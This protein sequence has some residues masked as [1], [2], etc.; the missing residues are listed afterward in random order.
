[1]VEFSNYAA[2]VTKSADVKAVLF[3]GKRVTTAWTAVPNWGYSYVAF[4][5][6]HGAHTFTVADGSSARLAAFAYGHSPLA[7]S[8]SGY[9]YTAGFESI[10]PF[11]H[12]I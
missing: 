1:M 5:I 12:F 8:S 6:T 2:I 4:P 11:H 3:D 9:G 10:T 7:A